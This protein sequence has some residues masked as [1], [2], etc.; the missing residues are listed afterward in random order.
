MRRTFG[1]AVAA[2]A[3]ALALV[4][5]A[6]AAA[7]ECDGEEAAWLRGLAD[8][9]RLRAEAAEAEWLVYLALD[10]VRREDHK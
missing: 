3:R 4:E 6:E 9:A 1:E 8:A 5:E 10:A 7:A 2:H